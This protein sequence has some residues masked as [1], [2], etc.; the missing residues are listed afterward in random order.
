MDVKTDE[1]ETPFYGTRCQECGSKTRVCRTTGK[2][3]D[4]YRQRLCQ[5]DKCKAKLLTREVTISCH[6]SEEEVESCHRYRSQPDKEWASLFQ[7]HGLPYE[8]LD[9]AWCDFIVDGMP[10]KV[11]C[12][13]QEHVSAAI[14][15]MPDD[16]H[17]AIACGSPQRS[18][19]V[20]VNFGPSDKLFRAFQIT[21]QRHFE[22]IPMLVK[23]NGV[24]VSRIDGM[25]SSCGNME[26][27]ESPAGGLDVACSVVGEDKVLRFVQSE[28]VSIAHL[29]INAEASSLQKIRNYL[30][31]GALLLGPEFSGL[32][33]FGS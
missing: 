29:L 19:S 3:G 7:S 24:T 1:S 27:V 25:R 16:R 21:A 2:Y 31:H 23:Q 9:G 6:P 30:C 14:L 8:Y 15:Q 13:G 28:L 18:D 20:W 22:S 17:V 33:K 5:N 26:L 10:V 12:T 32:E 4:I 11:T